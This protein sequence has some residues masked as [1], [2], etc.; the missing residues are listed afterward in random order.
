MPSGQFTLLVFLH[1]KQTECKWSRGLWTDSHLHLL[2]I[3]TKSFIIFQLTKSRVFLDV[4][5][6]CVYGVCLLCKARRV[7]L[8]LKAVRA[9]A[10]TC[11]MP[12]GNVNKSKYTHTRPHVFIPFELT[13]SKLLSKH[14]LDWADNVIKRDTSSL[15]PAYRSPERW[16]K[17]FYTC[18][19][20]LT[21]VKLSSD[22]NK[23]FS[24]FIWLQSFFFLSLALFQHTCLKHLKKIQMAIHFSPCC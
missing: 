19:G 1:N 20:P 23:S 8:C 6:V 16:P 5:G 9:Q 3:S 15:F 22:T 18:N 24:P 21:L 4:R 13:D 11:P 17:P 10:L 7:P 12:Q 2:M 14:S